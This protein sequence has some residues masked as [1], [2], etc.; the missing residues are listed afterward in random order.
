MVLVCIL[1]YHLTFLSKFS[2]FNIRR[3]IFL[4]SSPKLRKLKK[5]FV[6]LL[7]FQYKI[8][9]PQH[10]VNGFSFGFRSACSPDLES[11]VQTVLVEDIISKL[12]L[13]G[14]IVDVEI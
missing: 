3:F 10:P 14:N 13:S 2:W 5:E 12:E 9:F 8:S 6:Q 11:F 4:D 7:E 1:E